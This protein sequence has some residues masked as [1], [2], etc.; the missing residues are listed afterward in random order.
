M[1]K[2]SRLAKKYSFY[3]PRLWGRWVVLS[4]GLAAITELIKPHP[5]FAQVPRYDDFTALEGIARAANDG[6]FYLVGIS[7][8]LSLTMGAYQYIIAEGD[9]KELEAAKKAITWAVIGTFI[10]AAAWTFAN[11]VWGDILGAPGPLRFVVPG[12]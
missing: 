7:G 9:P 4:L 8:L 1:P 2:K 3:L 12:P 10:G 5:A 11:I 6:L